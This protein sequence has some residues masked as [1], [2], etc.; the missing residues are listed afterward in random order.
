MTVDTAFTTFPVL[1]TPRLRL[2]GVE[3]RDLPD[4]FAI[5]SHEEAMRHYGFLPHRSIEETQAWYERKIQQYASHEALRWG[6]TF[7]D[8]DRV[9][10]SVSFH[11]FGADFHHVEVGYD[12][13]PDYWRQ[14]IMS[15][16][17]SAVIDYGFS[18]MGLHRIEAMIDDANTA[19]KR[20][21]LSL[22]FQYEGRL[23]ERFTGRGGFEDEDFYGLLD[24]EWAARKERLSTG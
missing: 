15:E 10:G 16:A 14:G 18:E 2:R 17:V 20:L 4:L 6:V 9:I 22:G 19:S 8:A 21:L 12:L 1:T 23:R 24:R 3:L 11:R 5:F 7:P 13:H